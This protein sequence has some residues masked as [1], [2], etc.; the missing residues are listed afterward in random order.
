MFPLLV[1]WVVFC[2]LDV[3]VSCN[4]EE[5]VHDGAHVDELAEHGSLWDEH[6]GVGNVGKEGLD[7]ALGHGKGVPGTERVVSGLKS[8]S[9]QLSG[10]IDHELFQDDMNELIP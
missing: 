10:R 7:M 6:P 1:P 5:Y 3:L 2:E 4:V 8:S 9:E